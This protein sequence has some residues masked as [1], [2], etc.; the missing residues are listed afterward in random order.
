M[1]YKVTLKMPREQRTIEV[2][3]DEYILDAATE[4]GIDLPYTC[5]VGTC[6][7]CVA[8]LVSGQ[9]DQSEEAFLNDDQIKKGYVLTCVAYPRSNLTLVTN[10]EQDLY[11]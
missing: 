6:S 7:A 11:K 1:K 2:S 4:Y 10:C 9:V 8:K 5:K 3:D